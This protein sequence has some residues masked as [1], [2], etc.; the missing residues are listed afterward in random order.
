MSK[1]L[2]ILATVGVVLAQGIR[3]ET[4][5]FSS[6]AMNMQPAPSEGI[7]VRAGRMFDPLTG[8]NLPDQVI[9]IKGDRIVEVGPAARTQ[10]QQ[11]PA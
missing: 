11:E 10:F 4:P 3:P 5:Q 2:W 9:L 6:A 1:I 7:A 8:K